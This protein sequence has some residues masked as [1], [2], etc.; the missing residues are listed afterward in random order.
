M[1]ISISNG[2]VQILDIENFKDFA[3][4]APEAASNTEIEAALDALGRLHNDNEADIHQEELLRA[5]PSDRVSDPD[6]RS[7]FDAMIAYATSKG[8]VGADGAIRAHIERV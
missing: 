1:Q 4:I 6:W 2:E 3:V 5:L 8:W 7:Q